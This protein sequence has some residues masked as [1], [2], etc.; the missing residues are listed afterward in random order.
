M[1]SFQNLS[2]SAF[3]PFIRGLSASAPRMWYAS[4][5]A[6]SRGRYQSF[7][8]ISKVTLKVGNWHSSLHLRKE[9]AV[10]GPSFLAGSSW[11]PHSRYSRAFWILIRTYFSP[12]QSTWPKRAPLQGTPRCSHRRRRGSAYSAR[13][14]KYWN[15]LPASVVKAPSVNI[16]KKR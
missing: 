14:V 6:N 9:T 8:A 15:K 5:F 7:T 12:S 1:H 11:L 4:L 10:T 13:V 2:K 16:F 3:T